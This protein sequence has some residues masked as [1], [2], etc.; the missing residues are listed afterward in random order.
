MEP[1]VKRSRKNVGADLEV[2]TARG[3]VVAMIE[4][5]KTLIEE[6][7]AMR[8]EKVF[9]LLENCVALGNGA[10]MLLLAK[11]CLDGIGTEKD[12]KRAKELISESAK[13]GN[14]EA[15]ALM[16]LMNRRGRVSELSVYSLLIPRHWCLFVVFMFIID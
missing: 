4:L 12:L 1:K 15:Q 2:S 5:A 11:C 13:K 14:K 3:H 7:G 16:D 9:S 6:Y 8:Q 10:A